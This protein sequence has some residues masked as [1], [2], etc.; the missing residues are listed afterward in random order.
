LAEQQEKIRLEIEYELHLELVSES[1]LQ[2]EKDLAE[3]E[4]KRADIS[5]QA[6]IMR[7]D[8]EVILILYG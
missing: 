8:D 6:R 2:I 1:L 5:L 4:R 7:D 3:I